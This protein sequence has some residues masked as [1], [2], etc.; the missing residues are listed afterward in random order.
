[1]RD[2]N[3]AFWHFLDQVC[4]NFSSHD[5][6]VKRVFI[7]KG[8]GYCKS[9]KKNYFY[10]SVRTRPIFTPIL[11]GRSQFGVEDS[12]VKAQFLPLML[13][14]TDYKQ[15]LIVFKTQVNVLQRIDQ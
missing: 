5:I 14:M 8:K 11:V 15:P 1:M 9:L 6:C 13:R 4:G 7:Q 10:R 2:K 3:I 12:F